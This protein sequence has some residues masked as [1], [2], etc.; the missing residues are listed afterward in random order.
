MQIAETDVK[1]IPDAFLFGKI[2]TLTLPSE[3]L[4]SDSLE[5]QSAEQLQE[6]AAD[7]HIEVADVVRV[8]VQRLQRLAHVQ[9]SLHQHHEVVNAVRRCPAARTRRH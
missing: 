2:K 6:E 9:P 7:L 1:S 4:I 5:R 3:R 8:G